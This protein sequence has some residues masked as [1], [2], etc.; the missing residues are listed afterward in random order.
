MLVFRLLLPK[1]YSILLNTKNKVEETKFCPK[2]PKPWSNKDKMN[3]LKSTKNPLIFSVLFISKLIPFLR[4]S[5]LP[6]IGNNQNKF[7]CYAKK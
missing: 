2:L 1:I 6:K 4:N 7:I 5:N 3:K